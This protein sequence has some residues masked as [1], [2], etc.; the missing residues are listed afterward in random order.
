MVVTAHDGGVWLRSDA[1]TEYNKLMSSMIPTGTELTIME[2]KTSSEGSL[3]GKTEYNGITGWIYL[4]ATTKD[5][6][7]GTASSSSAASASGTDLTRYLGKDL[8]SVLSELPG[9][10]GYYNTEDMYGIG[11][12]GIYFPSDNGTENSTV[13][14]ISMNPSASSDYTLYGINCTMSIEDAKQKQTTGE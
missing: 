4:P 10:E 9:S 8:A 11:L 13:A 14:Y 12:G 7:S 6:S 5:D 2:E 1:G 3:W